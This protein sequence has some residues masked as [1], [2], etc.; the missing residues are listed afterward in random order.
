LLSPAQSRSPPLNTKYRF[1][2][3]A[4][5]AIVALR[6][7]IGWHFYR[8]GA[9]KLI[10][11]DFKSAAF[12]RVATGP[13]TPLFRSMVWDIDGRARLDRDGTLK[14]WEEY[15]Q[16]VSSHYGFDEAQQKQVETVYKTH[17]ERLDLFFDENKEEI[18]NYLKGLDR[19]DA[20]KAAPERQELESLWAQSKKIEREMIQ[21]AGPW[22]ATIE[23][24][25]RRYEADLNAVA[26]E[27]Q[28]NS[29][30]VAVKPPRALWMYTDFIDCIIPT[31]DLIVGILLVT[32]LC[33][34]IA[35]VAGAVFLATIVATQW[36][37]ALG[38][39][40]PHYQ[41]IETFGLLVLAV[42]GAG[43]FAGLD[44]LL[45]HLPW[46]R[47]RITKFLFKQYMTLVGRL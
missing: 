2:I 26:T 8:E 28:A 14:V 12:M 38:H 10:K 34:R 39:V 45:V 46:H 29:G 31:F 23:S 42:I 11:G 41:V 1:G 30:T 37:W 17:K 47:W 5:I 16:K 25:W 35:A 43:R 6:L 36:P 33:T 3:V 7:V 4:A 27:E 40:P 21:K 18:A 22:L 44:A 13:L 15:S 32:G 20:N 19:R 24:M 9:D